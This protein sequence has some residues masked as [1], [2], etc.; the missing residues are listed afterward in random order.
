MVIIV[1]TNAGGGRASRRWVAV[2][3]ELD[4]SGLDGT[5]FLNRTMPEL[6]ELVRVRYARGEQTFI[7]AGGDGTVNSMVNTLAGLAGPGSMSQL[8]VGAVGLGSSND[9]H[10]PRRLRRTIRGTPVAIDASR[11]LPRDAVSVNITENGQTRTRWFLLNGGFGV[12]AAANTRFNGGGAVLRFLKHLSTPAAILVAIVRT[13]I[14]LRDFRLS[15]TSVS[16]EPASHSVTN[17]AVLKSPW[18]SGSLSFPDDW[19]APGMMGVVMLSGARRAYL[20]RFLADLLRG[21]CATST[22]CSHYLTPTLI[23][24]SEVPVALEIDGEIVRGSRF[25]FNVH[26]D[27]LRVCT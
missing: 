20:V 24:A 3:G 5:A 14:S 6:L 11:T 17:L 13:L 1:N 12:T 25:A 21:R 23:V 4:A 16:G 15:V 19:T 26:R 27:F 10:K 2:R 7:A 18:V 8:S 9:F 22:H